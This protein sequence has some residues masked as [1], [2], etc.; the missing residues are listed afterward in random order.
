AA[1]L[2]GR[3]G[4]GTR[5]VR[6]PRA[7]WG[8]RFDA[9]LDRATPCALG[10]RRRA[11]SRRSRGSPASSEVV[12]R[13]EVKPQVEDP[14]RAELWRGPG[15]RWQRQRGGVAD[16]VGELDAPA[17]DHR[18]GQSRLGGERAERAVLERRKVEHQR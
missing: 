14:G 15:R 18:E 11:R 5:R 6:T 16:L 7:S 12:P 9:P 13:V 4:G 3:R 8:P 17:E 2:A 10:L 1:F